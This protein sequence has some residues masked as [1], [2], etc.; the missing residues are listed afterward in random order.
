M[1][2]AGVDLSNGKTIEAISDRVSSAR[3]LLLAKTFIEGLDAKR[4]LQQMTEATNGAA[5]PK[6]KQRKPRPGAKFLSLLDEMEAHGRRLDEKAD[7]LTDELI[8]T[9][10]LA[11]KAIDE[12]RTQNEQV[13][14][15]IEQVRGVADRLNN[16]GPTVGE[17]SSASPRS[18]NDQNSSQG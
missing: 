18:S 9:E 5:A 11:E 15:Y 14:D 6:P 10:R 2:P 7:A 8:E 12:R 17:D 3:A 4:R 1:T 13:R 16:G